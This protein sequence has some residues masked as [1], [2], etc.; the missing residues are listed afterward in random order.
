MGKE[1]G[2][3]GWRIAG[4][5][6]AVLGISVASLL[7]LVLIALQVVLSSSFLTPTLG[8]VAAPFV[9]GEVSIGKVRASV[10]RSFPNLYVSIDTVSITYPHERFAAYDSTGLQS[11]LLRSGRSETADTLASFAGL[12]A[13]VDYIALLKHRIRIP[14]VE[15]D[16]FRAHIH[17]YDSTA[18]NLSVLILPSSDDTSAF[19]MPDISLGRVSIEGGASMVYT[20]QTD[21]T[22][23]A[24]RLR[25]LALEEHRDH[26]DIGADAR[27]FAFT[28]SLGRLSL[29]FDLDCEIAYPKIVDGV[30][31]LSILGLD[32]HVSALPLQASGEVVLKQDSTY[33]DV[34][35]GVD[36][37][38]VGEL[39]SAYG[40]LLPQSLSGL[41]TDAEVTATA[42]A[43]GWYS[44]VTGA[45]PQVVMHVDVP[46]AH[47]SHSDFPD[48][49][50]FDLSL[51]ARNSG[52][53]VDVDL[54]DFCFDVDGLFLN[55]KGAAKDL[56]GEDPLFSLDMKGKTDLA[57]MMRF[58][59]QELGVEASG[60]VDLQLGGK[61]R[62]S[63]MDLYGVTSSSLAGSLTGDRVNMEYS[64]MQ[65]MLQNPDIQLLAAGDGP[66]VKAVADSMN[67]DLGEGM[68]VNGSGIS[69]SLDNV[70]DEA[71]SFGLTAALG[72][73]RLRMS[74][75]DSLG[76]SM[77]RSSNTFVLSQT[78]SYPKLD[79]RSS[80][81]VVFA[82]VGDHRVA[83]RDLSLSASA[84]KRQNGGQDRGGS[85]F[86]E[87][88]RMFLDSLQRVYPDVPRDSLLILARG[89]MQMPDF[90]T[91][92]EFA[93]KDIDISLSGVLAEY[94]DKWK[95][96]VSM[97]A[98]V[99]MVV[100]PML[101][102]R[103][104][105]A[106][107]DAR[108]DE[109][110]LTVGSLTVR[111]GTSD[112]TASGR[113]TGLRSALRGRRSAMELDLKLGSDRINANELMAALATADQVPA[114][115]EALSGDVSSVGDE[116]KDAYV[117]PVSEQVA[118]DSLGAELLQGPAYSL[119]VIPANLNAKV[120]LDAR[121]IDWADL[122]IDS[123]R[124]DLRMRER[125]VQVTNA[126]MCSELG[127]VSLD[128]FYSTRTK[129]DIKAG[130]DLGLRDVTAE[131]VIR[132]F[133]VIDSLVPMLKS[134]KGELDCE[135][136]ATAQLDTNMNVQIPSVSG[137]VKIGG[138]HLILEDMGSLRKL[139]K[140]LMFKDTESG[141][142]DHMSVNGIVNDNHLEVFPFLLDVDRYSLALK[143]RQNFDSSFNYHISVLK[144]PLPFKF[145][146]DLTGN[147]D[148]WK[149]TIGRAQFTSARVP[150]FTEEIDGMQMNL[151]TSIR[152]I[153]SKGVDGAMREN[154]R[155]L[156]ELDRRRNEELSASSELLSREELV[157]MDDM[158]LNMEMQAEEEALNAELE[159]L[160]GEV[161]PP[162]VP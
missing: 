2:R 87:R 81:A 113:L 62:L 146:I 119:I 115:E 88:R 99:G 61:I 15:L 26:I 91:E 32:A 45:L 16:R 9:D 144:S 86:R 89:R 6:A 20:H 79:W 77:M 19:E 55:L 150:V 39:L 124:S 38:R 78:D 128:G 43:E 30:T 66:I 27:A 56:L 50:K 112:V 42:T 134:F 93:L 101:P 83:M 98:P 10:F 104:T 37:C 68:A 74:E 131:K 139:A 1:S 12:R 4:R 92:K 33:V 132:M 105:F 109:N 49:A 82:R 120:R 126:M 64:G 157:Q 53:V 29:P 121:R 85:A 160:L 123:L 35:V 22:L 76:V 154:G 57:K 18:S 54:K 40:T 108:F 60:D 152:E 140:T 102:L 127:N 103:C 107:L 7:L 141:Y 95:P 8:K 137:V 36:R 21:S 65:A 3:S 48:R 11:R 67:V 159:E 28:P 114:G 90:L 69:L 110:S 13:S 135:M 149:Y 143:G 47:I 63:Q 24:L 130:F 96:S 136:A 58:V 117:A 51:D 106:D 133:P 72:A 44:A 52:R 153:F 129:K 97:K 23:A 147:F 46:D 125:T 73:G 122:V 41:D 5:V 75:G 80:D 84:H 155:A 145:G 31:E 162:V 17:F 34:L 94:F 116:L 151:L 71:G 59:P 70:R 25:E 118:A 100:T 158:L 138:R 148:D 161:V 14:M 156:G 142:I 111:A